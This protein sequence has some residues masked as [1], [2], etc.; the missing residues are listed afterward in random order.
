MVTYLHIYEISTTALN[1]LKVTGGVIFATNS[2]HCWAWFQQKALAAVQVGDAIPGL[3]QHSQ[4]WSLARGI[5]DVIK[6]ISQATTQYGRARISQKEQLKAA[7]QRLMQ[8][9]V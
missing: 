5:R 7:K 6:T 4:G 9:T 1:M 3:P 2:Q 8:A